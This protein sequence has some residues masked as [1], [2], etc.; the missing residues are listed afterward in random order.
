VEDDSARRIVEQVTRRVPRGARRVLEIGCG[1]GR[2][3]SLLV[4]WTGTLTAVDPDLEAVRTASRWVPEGVF[5]V[6]SGEALAFARDRFD[7]A[8]FTLSLHH[9]DSAAALREASRVVAPGGEIIVVEPVVGGEIEAVFSAVHDEDQAKRLA[10]RAVGD[11]GLRVVEQRFFRAAWR[12]TD[13][14]DLYRA[15]F[16]YYG[17]PFDRSKADRIDAALGDKRGARPIVLEDRMVI[18]VLAVV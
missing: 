7:R 11:S 6:G 13:R 14:D 3:S 5:C 18:Q 8:V 4:A 10:Q 9:Q 12:F 1:D 16:G 15:V 17:L 2:V